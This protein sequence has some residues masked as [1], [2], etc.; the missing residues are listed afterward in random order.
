[1]TGAFRE[2]P[3]VK[4]RKLSR[5]YRS[6]VQFSLQTRNLDLREGSISVFMKIFQKR[7]TGIDRDITRVR[8]NESQKLGK[9]QSL[10]R[11][12]FSKDGN[13]FRRDIRNFVSEE[14]WEKKLD[15]EEE[16]EE[17]EKKDIRRI[18]IERL[19]PREKSKIIL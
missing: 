7:C 16:D 15:E 3:G 9:E 18:I 6:V 14:N 4:S 11:Y 1:M 13:Y 5:N 2:Y 19:L 17:E 12:I 10:R 8:G